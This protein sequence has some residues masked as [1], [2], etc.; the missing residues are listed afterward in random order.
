MYPSITVDKKNLLGTTQTV[1]LAKRRRLAHL[2]SSIDE[3]QKTPRILRAQL[4]HANWLFRSLRKR[5]LLQT[6]KGFHVLH[7]YTAAQIF[8]VN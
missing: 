1:A 2:L 4:Q 3:K 5:Q 8:A 6:P 7:P